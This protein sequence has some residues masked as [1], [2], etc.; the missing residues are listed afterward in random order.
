M[1]KALSHVAMKCGNIPATI[2]L[3]SKHST[4]V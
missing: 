1:A 4:T 3:M 2:D